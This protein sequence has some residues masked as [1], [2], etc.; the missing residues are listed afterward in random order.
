MYVCRYSHTYV[1]YKKQINKDMY[2]STQQIRISHVKKGI[3]ETSQ[4]TILTPYVLFVSIQYF[5]F[6]LNILLKL[7]IVH[8]FISS[9]QLFHKV[10]PLVVMQ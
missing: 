2:F 7:L 3:P 8:D 6:I 1:Q 10:T 9:L 5:K 4:Y